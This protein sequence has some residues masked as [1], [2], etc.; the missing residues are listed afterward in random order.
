MAVSWPYFYYYYYYHGLSLT[1]EEEEDIR[2]TLGRRP[3]R[4]REGGAPRKTDAAAPPPL[5]ERDAGTGKGG[6]PK[7]GSG[8]QMLSESST[9]LL[10]QG[11]PQLTDSL[12][13]SRSARLNR[14]AGPFE[15][16]LPPLSSSR[17]EILISPL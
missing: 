6:G 9:L 15:G 8:M 1:E 13:F 10:S 4:G 12:D 17:R 16:S 5:P 3:K 2:N 11:A 14:R 7:N